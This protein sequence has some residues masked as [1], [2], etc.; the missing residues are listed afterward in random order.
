MVT[1]AAPYCTQ[2]PEHNRIELFSMSALFTLIVTLQGVASIYPLLDAVVYHVYPTGQM[3]IDTIFFPLPIFGLFRICAATWLT[4][5]FAYRMTDD[6]QMKTLPF[7]PKPGA[8]GAYLAGLEPPIL[9]ITTGRFRPTSYWAS[10][11]FRTIF[12]LQFLGI[13]LICFAFA[14]PGI[15][16]HVYT[17]TAFLA[18]TYYFAIA[19]VTIVVYAYYSIRGG[20]TST[21]IPCFSTNWYRLYSLCVFGATGVLILI[22]AIE[23]NKKV[24]NDQYSSYTSVHVD[25]GVS[26]CPSL[27]AVQYMVGT[28]TDSIFFGLTSAKNKTVIGDELG[29]AWMPGIPS[30]GNNSFSGEMW[31]YNFTGYC[32]GSPVL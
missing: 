12:I 8:K 13:W 30:S 22:S 25:W 4:G 27:N 23:T 10:R 26:G 32:V 9:H 19:T 6:T 21:I 5:D 2:L 28:S 15:S 24:G 18:S 1:S 29:S 17:T 14:A 3:G 31:T 7:K 16:S 20:T 11:V